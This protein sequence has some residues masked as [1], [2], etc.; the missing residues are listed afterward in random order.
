[1]RQAALEIPDEQVE[2]REEVGGALV[3]RGDGSHAVAAS[4]GAGDRVAAMLHFALEKNVDVAVLERL[5]TLQERVMERDAR[6]AFFAALAAFQEEC[7]PIQKTRKS[8]ETSEAGRQQGYAWAPLD[9]IAKTIRP[10]LA[11]HGL[12]Y[13]WSEKLEGQALAVTCHLRHL[14]GHS[15]SSTFT[16]PTTTKFGMSDQQK[17]GSAGQY[18]RRYSLVNVL[19]ITTTDE[20][21][22]AGD[23]G[24]ADPISEQQ[25]TY[26]R[27]LLE[28]TGSDAGKFLRLMG[29]E[30]LEQLPAGRYEGARAA[31]EEKLAKLEEKARREQA[32]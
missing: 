22:E 20:D 29:A 12:S 27:G 8:K 32:S 31:L 13:N 25:V 28:R 10:V 17:V 16:C 1:M 18:G 7:P 4:G 26:L 30:T 19:G 21:H 3:R 11:K 23:P 9:E 6:A 5:V 2:E 24:S 15:E 14:D